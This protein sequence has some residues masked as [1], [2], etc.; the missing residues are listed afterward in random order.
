MILLAS[1]ASD[2]HKGSSDDESPSRQELVVNILDLPLTKSSRAGTG[3]APVKEFQQGSTRGWIDASGA[4]EIGN[5]VAHT[6][7]RCGTYEVGVQ[8]GSGDPRCSKVRWR[9]D[10]QYGTRRTHCN[11]ATLIHAGG[12]TLPD[13][14]YS[15]GTLSCVRVVTRCSGIC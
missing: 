6:R 12:G 2:G 5:P 9:T 13:W 10:V 3:Q 14:D 15:V 8:F 1:C 7:L 4:W 11:S